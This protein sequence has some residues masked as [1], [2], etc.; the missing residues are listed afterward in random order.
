MWHSYR[1]VPLGRRQAVPHC[2]QLYTTNNNQMCLTELLGRARE[3]AHLV[4]HLSNTQDSLDSI[5]STI[6]TMD[7]VVHLCKTSSREAEAGV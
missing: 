6:C 4:E 7:A 2:P 5:L 3:T 1:A